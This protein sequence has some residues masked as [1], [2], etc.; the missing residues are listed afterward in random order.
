MAENK[1][2][3]DAMKKLKWLVLNSESE[4]KIQFD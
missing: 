1:T 2:Y 4:N 3:A